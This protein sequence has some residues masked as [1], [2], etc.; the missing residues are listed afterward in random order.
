MRCSILHLLILLAV[1]G[2]SNV[3]VDVD[4]DRTEPQEKIFDEEM[5]GRS[6]DHVRPRVLELPEA[7]YPPEAAELDLSG[8]VL[9]KVL[10]G[11]DGQVVETQVS[12]GLHPVLDQAALDA[13]RRGRYAPATES[14]IAVD[15][16]LT[17]PFRYPPDGEGKP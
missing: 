17:V 11:H 15:G 7:D 2:C 8:L 16:W 1:T 6:A 4:S 13:A 14:E 10:V 3:N 5:T 12:Q 9:I